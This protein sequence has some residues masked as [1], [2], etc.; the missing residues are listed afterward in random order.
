MFCA[1]YRFVRGNYEERLK[2][3]AAV[4]AKLGTFLG[5]MPMSPL[6]Q[7]VG[8]CSAS[9]L[10]GG[11]V[12]EQRWV[13]VDVGETCQRSESSRCRRACGGPCPVASVPCTDPVTVCALPPAVPGHG[14]L[15]APDDRFQKVLAELMRAEPWRVVSRVPSG[16]TVHEAGGGGRRLGAGGRICLS[17][18]TQGYVNYASETTSGWCPRWEEGA[19]TCSLSSEFGGQPRLNSPRFGETVAGRS[20]SSSTQPMS[21]GVDVLVS[22]EVVNKG[23]SSSHLLIRELRRN[24]GCEFCEGTRFAL[25]CAP[26]QLNPADAPSRGRPPPWPS[27]ALPPGCSRGQVDSCAVMCASRSAAAP[28]ASCK[29]A[30]PAASSQC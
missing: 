10:E 28:A 19:P 4:L 6:W 18:L 15:K 7:E 16:K 27:A 11:G 5:L 20:L 26:S 25:H 1:S 29:P 12:C 22:C 24:W 8:R 13:K 30:E 21:S 2:V 9:R 3:R 14:E 23:R 17:G